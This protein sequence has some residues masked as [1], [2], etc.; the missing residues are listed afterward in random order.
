MSAKLVVASIGVDDGRAIVTSC[1]R[2]SALGVCLGMCDSNEKC[3]RYEVVL[4][5]CDVYGWN[6]IG[7]YTGGSRRRFGLG[8]C[9]NFCYL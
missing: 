4:H 9:S 2:G 1:D 6:V 3:D 5:G 8:K 7:A